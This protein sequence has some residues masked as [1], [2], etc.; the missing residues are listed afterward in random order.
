MICP[1]C[2][3]TFQ[4]SPAKESY[5]KFCSTAC[6]RR[7][8]GRR[9]RRE[10][11]SSPRNDNCLRCGKPM[12]G[13][14]WGAKYCGSECRS[15]HY[16]GAKTKTARTRLRCMRCGGR[17]MGNACREG[18]IERKYGT[19]VDGRYVPPEGVRVRVIEAPYAMFGDQLKGYLAK[20]GKV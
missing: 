11:R 4:P 15:I 12:V 3:A 17:H 9:A 10:G 6:R 8:K 20:R 1:I 7:E 13:K 2:N 14:P 19:V 5:Q 16:R 18:P